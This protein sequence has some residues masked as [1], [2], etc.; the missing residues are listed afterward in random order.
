M[1]IE[2]K[3]KV[4][5]ADTLRRLCNLDHLAC[6]DVLPGRT[7]E[8]HDTYLDSPD[9][10][11]LA[12]GFACRRREQGDAVR[13]TLKGLGGSD[14]AVHR[15]AEHEM[16]LP[17]GTPDDPA[18]CASRHL[19]GEA[20]QCASRHLYGE[21]ALWPAGPVRE[22]VLECIADAP[23]VPL[24]KLDQTRTQRTVMR[25]GLPV[26]ML[27]L[28]HVLVAAGGRR[29][30][31]WELEIELLPAGSEGDLAAMVA[32]LRRD[33]GLTPEPR[34]KFERGLALLD[35]GARWTQGASFSR[36]RDPSL[37]SG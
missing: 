2:A 9:R 7:H 33:G 25:D 24:F 30:E 20:A 29:D 37:R 16:L 36:G 12:A 14:G 10:R 13:I 3:W 15:R 28:D 5:D 26:A 22:Q 6:Y 1:E 8:V 31:Y 23:L 35:A 17:T 11:M 27:S 32:A 34:S 21:A 4:A 18:R 19:Y